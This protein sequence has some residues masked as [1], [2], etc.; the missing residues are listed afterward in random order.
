MDFAL[1][2]TRRILHA[3]DKLSLMS[4]PLFD[5]FLHAFRIDHRISR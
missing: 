4:L 1:L 5:E 3:A 2:G